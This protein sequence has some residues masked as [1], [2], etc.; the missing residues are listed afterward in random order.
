MGL[1]VIPCK[2]NLGCQVRFRIDRNKRQIR[3]RG[4]DQSDLERLGKEHALAL[5]E[6]R[7]KTKG[8]LFSWGIDGTVRE[9]RL[10]N[11]DLPLLI[12]L[13]DHFGFMV[14]EVRNW[15][16]PVEGRKLLARILSEISDPEKFSGLTVENY[17]ED[18]G[19]WFLRYQGSLALFKEGSLL[20]WSESTAQLINRVFNLKGQPIKVRRMDLGFERG[21][22]ICLRANLRSGKEQ[23]IAGII[24]SLKNLSAR[25][26]RAEPVAKKL[27]P[28]TETEV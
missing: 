13:R 6:A 20:F 27:G 21:G 8:L 12:K 25:K 24:Y 14:K 15:Q 26:W 4:S 16:V 17:S 22:E 3:F 9:I 18:E 23:L 5:R 11:S 10:R 2:G 1:R 7:N 28:L 19:F